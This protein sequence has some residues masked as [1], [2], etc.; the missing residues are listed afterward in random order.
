[1]GAVYLGD[2]T[3]YARHFDPL[4][5]ASAAPALN[6]VVNIDRAAATSLPLVSLACVRIRDSQRGRLAC[7]PAAI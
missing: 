1:M 4:R 6:S 3:P 7:R 2:L 5:S